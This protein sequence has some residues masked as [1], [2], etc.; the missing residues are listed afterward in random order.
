MYIEDIATQIFHDEFESTNNSLT[1][2]SGW[3]ENNVGKLNNLI[4]TSFASENSY[5][6]GLGLEE[7]NI[8]KEMY[9]QHYYTKET[10]NILRG[11]GSNS[12]GNILSVKDADSSVSFVNK[13]EVSKVYRGLAADAEERLQKLVHKYNIY[14]SSPSQVGGIEA[15]SIDFAVPQQ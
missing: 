10:R 3:L 12:N 7:Q 14:R 11:I 4:N 5:I 13:N 15:Q 1:K 2:I 9:M 8:Y 6:S